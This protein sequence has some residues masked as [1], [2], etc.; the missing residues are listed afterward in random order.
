MEYTL[1]FGPLLPSLFLMGQW[2]EKYDNV[3]VDVYF[4][5]ILNDL[6]S[7]HIMFWLGVALKL[8][9]TVQTYTMKW[10]KNNLYFFF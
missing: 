3:E 5:I 8:F 1:F 2:V 10:F 6:G 4:F 7:K 9:I